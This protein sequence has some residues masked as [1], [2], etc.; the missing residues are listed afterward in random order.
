MESFSNVSQEAITLINDMLNKDPLAR[1]SA[2]ECLKHSWFEQPPFLPYRG[3]I[4]SSVKDGAGVGIEDGLRIS[5]HSSYLNR[6][7]RNLQDR[8]SLKLRGQLSIAQTMPVQNL[9]QDLLRNGIDL[10]L[11]TDCKYRHSMSMKLTKKQLEEAKRQQEE[12]CS[13]TEE[14]GLHQ[15]SC[16]DDNIFFNLASSNS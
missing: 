10:S 15:E 1:P 2:A 3:S 12:C 4:V 8:K 5:S 14:L 16:D 9:I 13:P 11:L 6:A 7:S